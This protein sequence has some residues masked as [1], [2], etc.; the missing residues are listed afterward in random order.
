MKNLSYLSRVH[1]GNITHLAVIGIGALI[2]LWLDGI[3]IYVIFFAGLNALIAYFIRFNLVRLE[4]QISDVNETVKAA[5]LGDF[6]RRLTSIHDTGSIGKLSWNVN[7][8]M[9]QFESFVREINASIQY[10]G[11]NVFFRRIDANGLN[12]AFD[13]S[14]GLINRAIDAMEEEYGVKKRETFINKLSGTGSSLVDS[15]VIIQKQLS[16]TAGEVGKSAKAAEETAGLAEATTQSVG[17]VTGSLNELI[18]MIQQNDAAVEELS[19]RSV[20]INSI[21]GLIKDIADQTTLLALNAAIEAARA[22]DH[23][24]GFAVV[25]DEVRKLA[26]RTQKAT[27]EIS[28]SIQTFQQETTE[29]KTTAEHMT[30]IAET[31]SRSIDAFKDSLHTF[32]KN[33]QIAKMTALNTESRVMIVLSKIDHILFKRETF[34]RVSAGDGEAMVNHENC[35]FGKWYAGYGAKHFSDI[36]EYKAIEGVHKTVHDEAN[37]ALRCVN[38]ADGS[39]IEDAVIERF[40]KMESSSMELFELMDRMLDIWLSNHMTLPNERK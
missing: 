18:E 31:S 35:R 40:V 19:H 38:A 24:R 37:G 13:Y 4:D 12:S 17:E 15:F 8:F 10:A 11:E 2:T 7:N 33:S 27:T 14:A 21:L 5:S 20:E 23:G 3:S 6:E 34:E 26:E 30:N 29:I 36:P 25:A 28:I 39:C 16:E 32:A 1:Y 9:D 22:G